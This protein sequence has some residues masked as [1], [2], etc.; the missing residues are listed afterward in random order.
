LVTMPIA[1]VGWLADVWQV[2]PEVRTAVGTV[3]P[4]SVVSV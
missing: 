3:A 4:L 2:V 1:A